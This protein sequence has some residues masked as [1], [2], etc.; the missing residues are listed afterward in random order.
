MDSD[1]SNIT[2]KLL[3]PL[4]GDKVIW[5]IFLLLVVISLV[6]VFSAT[7]YPYHGGSAPLKPFFKHTAFVL[8][9]LIL[10]ILLSNF[11]YRRFSTAS[12]AGYLVSILLLII[13]L[14]I[15]SKDVEAGSGMGRWIKL[16]LIGR[17]Q[18]SEL[19]KIVII[20]YLA[21][22]L[23]KEQKTLN[24]WP[25][26]RN[27]MLY[28]LVIV[29]L[30]V[31]DNLST[32]LII[33]IV[34]FAM[35]RLA[36]IEVKYWRR[37]ILGLAALGLLV[38]FIGEKSQ[39]PFLARAET[40]SGRI[41]RWLNFDQDELSQESMAR[42]AVASG[43]FFGA[44]VGSTVQARLMTQANSDMIYAIIVEETG[45]FGGILVF[46]LYLFLY[47]RCIRIAWRCKG[48]FGQLTV[49]GL[50]TL[51]FMQAGIH[52]CV[53]VGALPVTGQTLP[54]ISSGGTAYLCMS[55]AIGIIQAVAYDT[56]I[57]AP[58]ES[59]ETAVED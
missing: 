15:G 8:V 13:A 57:E 53:S 48:S 41:D 29:A 22:M 40:W 55:M 7:G 49:V 18:P 5:F 3:N 33:F 56:K 20:V 12:W 2:R 34:C 43:K 54:L 17:F 52:M 25:T 39:I 27:I 59:R 11:D 50:G 44:G 4:K 58:H 47:I 23:T 16:P 6:S 35:M 31:R 19:A 36:P 51:I 24:T 38:I 10:A 46:L 26:M 42:M 9:S 14:T 30:I 37:T 1:N 28:V 21:R 32:S 45:M